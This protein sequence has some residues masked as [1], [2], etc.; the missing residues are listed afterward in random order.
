MCRRNQLLGV[1]LL[2]FGAGLLLAWCIESVF[3]C[4]FFGV[5]SLLAGIFVLQRG[6]S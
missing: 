5:G 3:W 6:R 1:A 4:S 2:G